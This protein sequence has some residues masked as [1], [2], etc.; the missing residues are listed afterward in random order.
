MRSSSAPPRTSRAGRPAPRRGAGRG[1]R[2]AHHAFLCLIPQ[3]SRIFSYVAA[4]ARLPRPALPVFESFLGKCLKFNLKVRYTTSPM[5][6]LTGVAYGVARTHSGFVDPGAYFSRKRL[7]SMAGARISREEGLVLRAGALLGNPENQSRIF[8]H[9]FQLQLL[10]KS[11]HFGQLVWGGLFRTPQGAYAQSA[12]PI[13]IPA[14]KTQ[15]LFG[16]PRFL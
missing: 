8:I 4:L 15:R 16:Y 10:R 3:S 6:S 5:Y 2:G 11:C 12:Q 9:G 1:R 7:A 14:R 13:C